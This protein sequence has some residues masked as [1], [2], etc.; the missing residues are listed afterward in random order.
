MLNIRRVLFP[1]D[2]SD[3]SKRAM[4]HAVKLAQDHRAELHMLHAIV[5]HEDDPHDPSHHFPDKSKIRELLEDLAMKRLDG[6]LRTSEIPDLVVTQVHRRGVSAAPPI[7][8]YA[9]EQDVDV[10]VMG[11]HGRRGVRKM[12]MGSVAS[13]VVRYAPCAVMTVRG[14]GETAPSHD[15]RRILV[16]TDF[17]ESAGYALSVACEVASLS[18]AKLDLVHVLPEILHPTFYTMG[19]T[20]I[21]G[22]GDG[23]FKGFESELGQ[24]LDEAE[25]CLG[26]SAERHLLEGHPGREIVRFSRV[27]QGDL[28][29]MA[30]H[31]LTGIKHFLLGS[32]AEQ[33]LAGAEC[34]VLILKESGRPLLS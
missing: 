3:F 24:L 2:F 11:T 7:V 19:M 18:G 30:T 21:G 22:V 23:A 1:T 14:K 28:V 5:L 6:L 34:P 4:S 13:E 27:S 10:I 32:T 17:S 15:L 31:G 8:E 33:V 29:V 9:R 25:G 12:I 20:R 16:P 26:V